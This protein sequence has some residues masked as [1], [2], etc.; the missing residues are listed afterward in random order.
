MKHIKKFE[1][2]EDEKFDLGNYPVET[3]EKEQE[4]EPCQDDEGF[5]GGEWSQE[6]E[7]NPEDYASEEDAE[8]AEEAEEH[9]RRRLWGDE[10][11]VERISSFNNFVKE[12]KKAKPDFLDLDKDGDKKESMKKAAKDAKED[13]KDNNKEDKKET[14]G[15]SAAQKKLPPALQKAIAAK[16]K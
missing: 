6:D 10:A 3:R 4:C 11:T 15:L 9:E 7:F 1:S 5:P 12:A 2:F 14:K 13:K 16:K 8:E